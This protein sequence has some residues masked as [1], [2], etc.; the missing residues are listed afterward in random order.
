MRTALASKPR[1]NYENEDIAMPA[2]TIDEAKEVVLNSLPAS[3]E[4]E[5]ETLYNSLNASGERVAL[6]NLHTMRRKGELSARVDHET[7]KMYV[8]RPTT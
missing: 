1:I 6:R 5:Y 7:G 4:V 3:G 2:K 8:S